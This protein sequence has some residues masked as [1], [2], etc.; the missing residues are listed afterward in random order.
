MGGCAPSTPPM[1]PDTNSSGRFTDESYVTFRNTHENSSKIPSMIISM[2]K[3]HTAAGEY[4]LAEFYCDEY[5]RDFPS[6][7]KRAEVEYLSIKAMYLNNK[8]HRDERLSEMIRARSKFFF[9]NFPKSSYGSKI[10][11]LLENMTKEDN[12]YY[13]ELAKEYEK[14]G[15]PKAAEFY[16]SKIKK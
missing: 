1:S 15:K 5:R 2:I 12:A 11:T 8:Q 13:A 3:S 10:K 4:Q 7:K 14:R 6:G 16:R 9:A